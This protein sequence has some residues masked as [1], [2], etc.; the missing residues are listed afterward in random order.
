MPL[1]QGY[2]LS[3]KISGRYYYAALFTRMN[4]GKLRIILTTNIL[5]AIHIKNK[6]DA[7]NMLQQ[8]VT[9]QHF[10]IEPYTI[11]I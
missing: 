9:N 8:A 4:N 1:Q 11:L 5:K 3:T 7:I 10:N 6:E 2:V